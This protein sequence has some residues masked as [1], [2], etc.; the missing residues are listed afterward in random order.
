VAA[1]LLGL[2]FR[3][4]PRQKFHTL[5]SVVKC[6]VE[7]SGS[8]WSLVQRIPT[9]CGVSECDREASVMRKP[10]PTSGARGGAVVEAL[11]YKPEGRG[12]DSLCQ[13]NFSLT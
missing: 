5:V 6:Q 9:D 10:W 3:I 12:F 11:H 13:W 7:D 4:P 2:W 8:G 1:R